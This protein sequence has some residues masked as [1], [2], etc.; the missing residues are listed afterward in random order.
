MINTLKYLIFLENTLIWNPNKLFILVSIVGITESNILMIQPH[1]FTMHDNGWFS[2]KN[3]LIKTN[4]LIEKPWKKVVFILFS[5]ALVL[6]TYK[7]CLPYKFFM[8][9]RE[10]LTLLEKCPYSEFFWSIFSSNAGKY[11]P[12]KLGIRTHFTQC[13]L[14]GLFHQS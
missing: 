1:S 11:R 12:E 5:E 10:G 2:K 14:Q 7:T 8:R 4:L 3:K 13:K 9:V 6:Q